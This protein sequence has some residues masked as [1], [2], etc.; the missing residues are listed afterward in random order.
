[1]DV[2]SFPHSTNPR[3]H[4]EMTQKRVYRGP[5]S[6]HFW[7]L[8]S[9]HNC[10]KKGETLS[11]GQTCA[12]CYSYVSALGSWCSASRFV[13][14]GTCAECPLRIMPR[15]RKRGKAE[16]FKPACSKTGKKETTGSR[17]VK[18]LGGLITRNGHE[19]VRAAGDRGGNLGCFS[20]RRTHASKPLRIGTPPVP[21][22]RTPRPPLRR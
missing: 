17:G 16:R 1:M 8:V 10:Y 11:S 21:E 19:Q 20:E 22:V 7:Q 3:A 15:Y 5:C 14:M 12:F 4:A 9:Y 6:A 13:K 18:V 2:K